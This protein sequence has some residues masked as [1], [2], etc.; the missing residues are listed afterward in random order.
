MLGATRS[1]NDS[2]MC[3][4]FYQIAMKGESLI[5]SSKLHLVHLQSSFLHPQP[6]SAFV[7][8]PLDNFKL[9]IVTCNGL[10]IIL[11]VQFL[12]LSKKLFLHFP[13]NF[14]LPF[15]K[16]Q[17]DNRS[18]RFHSVQTPSF[19]LSTPP[20]KS[21]VWELAVERRP[22]AAQCFHC[23]ERTKNWAA[24]CLPTWVVLCTTLE[25]AGNW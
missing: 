22:A 12:S 3:W 17:T 4:L 24:W 13:D 1:D 23:H 8:R 25:S 6:M 16:W 2:F 20:T 11:D 9:S 10:L 19:C 7:L 21:K 18:L 14:L 5:A 15:L